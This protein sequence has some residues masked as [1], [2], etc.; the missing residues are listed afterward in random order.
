MGGGGSK[1]DSRWGVGTREHPQEK[2]W[3]KLYWIA[4]YCPF[5]KFFFSL[6]LQS[7]YMNIIQEKNIH[8]T[9]IANVHHHK[10]NIILKIIITLEIDQHLYIDCNNYDYKLHLYYHFKCNANLS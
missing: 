9:I 1:I 3:I 8:I 4:I 7:L 10:R 5:V 2:A 6:V